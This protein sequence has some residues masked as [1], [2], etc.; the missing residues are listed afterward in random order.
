VDYFSEMKFGGHMFDGMSK[1]I[2]I[3]SG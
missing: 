2:S 3:T 1:P